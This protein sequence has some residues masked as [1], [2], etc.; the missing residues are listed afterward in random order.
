MKKND[1]VIIIAVAFVA[2]IFSI[3]IAGLIFGGEKN[4]KLEAPVVNPI[5]SE[6]NSDGLKIYINKDS[7][8]ITKDITVQDNANTQPFKGAKQ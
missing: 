6:F 8:D 7:L 1:L 2:G 5:S 3:I 4:Y